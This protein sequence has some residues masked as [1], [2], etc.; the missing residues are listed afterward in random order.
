MGSIAVEKKNWEKAR[1][2][3]E[4]V[5]AVDEKYSVAYLALGKAYAGL[6]DKAKAKEVFQKGIKVAASKGDLM[7]ANQMQSELRLL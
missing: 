1:D 7:P 6:G 3:L 5:I 4:K 2:H